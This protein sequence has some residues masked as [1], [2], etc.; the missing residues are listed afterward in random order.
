MKST[1]MHHEVNHSTRRRLGVLGAL[2]L[3]LSAIAFGFSTPLVAQTAWSPSKP[4][5]MVIPYPPGGAT[6]VA[7]RALVMKLGDAL[8]QQFLI[9]I[10]PVVDQLIGHASAQQRFNGTQQRQRHRR[11][12]QL[13]QDGDIDFRPAPFG[14]GIGD[15]AK[16]TSDGFNRQ[17]Q[18]MGQP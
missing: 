14:H 4:I 12:Q 11:G 2:G 1:G 7:A 16:T 15:A 9:G 17:C 3:A 6:D 5:R 18:H 13:P 8:G 10:V